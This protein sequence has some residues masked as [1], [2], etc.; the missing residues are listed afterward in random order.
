MLKT[1]KN[2]KNMPPIKGQAILEFSF[3]MIV[4]LIMF[5]GVIKVF[6]WAGRD[7][8]ERQ[9]SH[10]SLLIGGSNAKD[11]ISPYYHGPTR[12]DAIWDGK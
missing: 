4:I 10:D 7:S 8:V 3:C 9:R 11:Q 2:I 6:H 5:Y 1:A 12:M